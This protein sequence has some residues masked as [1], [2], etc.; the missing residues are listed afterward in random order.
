MQAS[1]NHET[2]G[3]S[4]ILCIL[5]PIAGGGRMTERVKTAIRETFNEAGVTYEIVTTTL[6]G[7][8]AVLARDAVKQGYSR[9]VAIGGD[10][11]VNEVAT[12][13]VNTPSALG[14]IPVGSGNGLARGLGIPLSHWDAC[15]LIL[16]GQ[17]RKIDVGRVGE[18]YFFATSGVGFDA[19]VGKIYDERSGHGRGVLP[20]FQFAVTEF[21]NYEPQEVLLT[22]NQQTF[23]YTP[24]VLTIANVR[25]YGSGAIIAPRAVP[26]DG[27]FDL[28]IIPQSHVLEVLHH[29]PKLFMG[30]INTFPHFKSYRTDALTLTRAAEGP[31]HVDGEPFIGG[32][33]LQFTLL[34]HALNVL[35]DA[36]FPRTGNSGVTHQEGAMHI[37]DTLERLAQLKDNGVLTAEEFEEQ[38]RKLLER[39]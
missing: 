20:Y 25:E 32:R 23:R 4:P 13:L 9:V 1:N 21:F 5:N 17:C 10:G 30:T 8:A 37:L 27:Y 2:R 28:S 18:R 33:I 38:K 39:L 22:C 26:D 14:I 6:Q 16:H 11:T 35:V 29:L 24:F 15:R 36:A 12:G 34:P 3:L 19:H 31:A 7:E